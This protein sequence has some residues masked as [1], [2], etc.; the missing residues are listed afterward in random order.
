MPKKAFTPEQ[1][2]AKLRQIEVLVSQGKTV[3]LACK[4]SGITDQN[5]DIDAAEIVRLRSAACISAVRPSAKNPSFQLQVTFLCEDRRHGFMIASNRSLLAAEWTS[6]RP[7]PRWRSS[8]KKC[9][10]S[11][12]RLPK[13]VWRSPWCS[14]R[15]AHQTK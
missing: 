4:E 7:S 5:Q 8:P 2:V 12:R 6:T 11:T 13:A 15:Q 9:T 3:P 1:I 14:A 10:R